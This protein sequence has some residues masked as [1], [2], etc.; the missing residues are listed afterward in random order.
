MNCVTL[1]E[2]NNFVSWFRKTEFYLFLFVNS[3]TSKHFHWWMTASIYRSLRIKCCRKKPLIENTQKLLSW[4]WCWWSFLYC[5]WFV[6]FYM[7]FTWNLP[8]PFGELWPGLLYCKFTLLSMIVSSADPRAIC[9]TYKCLLSVTTISCYSFCRC[10]CEFYRFEK[11]LLILGVFYLIHRMCDINVNSNN[12]YFKQAHQREFLFDTRFQTP[13][14]MFRE[15]I[16][17]LL[18]YLTLAW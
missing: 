3:S 12:K 1:L 18:C 11:M 13:M 17:Y 4:W 5:F 2:N 8:L 9:N 7:F 6:F 14:F 15:P 10:Y 16:A